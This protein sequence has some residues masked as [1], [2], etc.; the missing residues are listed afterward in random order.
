MDSFQIRRNRRYVLEK[1]GTDVTFS[2]TMKALEQLFEERDVVQK[3]V[4]SCL[5]DE[6]N[7]KLLE[8][9]QGVGRQPAVQLMSIIVDI[10]RFQDSEK[11]C[12]Y[13]RLVPRVRDSDGMEH[14]GRITKNGDGMMRML[15]EHVTEAHIRYRNSFI[16]D[17]YKRLCPQM[18]TKKALITTSHKMLMTVYTVLK[19]QQEF[20]TR[21]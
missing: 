17:Y 10:D 5:Q 4:E 13:F 15:I 2:R 14:H 6:P 3:Q 1:Y 20:R 21:P 16:S 12:A 7:M 18:V 8:H 11:F 9:I 19:K